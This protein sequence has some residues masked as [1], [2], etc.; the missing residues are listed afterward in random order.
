MTLYEA[1]L[2]F[3]EAVLNCGVF[4]HKYCELMHPHCMC[5]EG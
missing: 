5:A 3:F 2:S 1:N 4:C